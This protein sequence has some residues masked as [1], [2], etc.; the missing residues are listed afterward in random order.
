MDRIRAARI[1]YCTLT[2]HY[3]SNFA[4]FTAAE[5]R[6]NRN[7]RTGAI[8]DGAGKVG[9]ADMSRRRQVRDKIIREYC[10]HIGR[11]SSVGI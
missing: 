7:Y 8:A 11:V 6:E 3:I 4:T 2:G 5:R 10:D 1:N 9:Q